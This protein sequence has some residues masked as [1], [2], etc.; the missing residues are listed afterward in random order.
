MTA[1]PIHGTLEAALYVDDLGAAEI[2]YAQVIGLAPMGKVAGR[3]VFFRVGNS[4]LLVFNPNATIRPA[5]PG[6]RLPVPVH[7]TKG[8]GHYCFA[9]AADDLD[10]WKRHL[11]AAGIRI[12]ADFCWPNGARSIYVR[13]PAGNSV[14]FAEPRLWFPA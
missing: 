1:P 12:E 11:E 9:V 8:Q 14:E 6:A 7:G 3:H 5:A 13:D 10:H 4:V 2:F